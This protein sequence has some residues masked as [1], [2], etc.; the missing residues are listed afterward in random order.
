MEELLSAHELQVEGGIMQHCVGTYT[1]YCLNGSAS[2]WSMRVM[3]GEQKKRVLT[4]EIC[5]VSKRVV[6]A[7][8]KRNT[9]PTATAY[10]MLKRWAANQNVEMNF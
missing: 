10:R 4:V 2:I 8:G 1:K 6:Q 5:P 3:Q 9:R 7:Q